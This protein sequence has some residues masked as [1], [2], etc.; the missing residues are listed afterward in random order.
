[1][2]AGIEAIKGAL[3]GFGLLQA[4]QHFGLAGKMMKFN[5]AHFSIQEFLS[6]YHITQL[7]P[8]EEL[9]ALEEKFWRKIHS[10][11][12]AIHILLTKGQR[13]A[14]KQFLSGGDNMELANLGLTHCMVEK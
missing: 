1:M 13:S 6:F 10:N 4:V 9:R 5:F 14:F 12:F 11:M 2:R 7:P 8:D 3:N